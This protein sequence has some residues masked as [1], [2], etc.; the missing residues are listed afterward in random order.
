MIR[1]PTPAIGPM[2][3]KISPQAAR[4][5]SAND[6]GPLSG[7]QVKALKA[8]VAILGALIVAA[9]LTIV[10]RVIYLSTV[11]KSAPAA[12]PTNSALA[13][14]HQLA[15]PVGAAIKNM[16]LQNNRLLVHYVAPSGPGAAI[17]DL[18]TGKL[19]STIVITAKPS[20]NK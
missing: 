15:L 10:A 4:Q 11:Q 7:G 1:H 5:S 14:E 20:A 9:L 18:T 3:S 8:I 12:T 13:E 16:S 6:N 17:L 2:Q 19:L